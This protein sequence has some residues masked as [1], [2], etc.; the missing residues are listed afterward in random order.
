[1]PPVGGQNK[2]IRFLKELEKYLVGKGVLSALS[3]AEALILFFSRMT[4]PEFYAGLKEISPS[5]KKKILSAAIKRGRGVPSGHI[6][7]EAYFC[8]HR[9]FVNRHVLTPRP[10]TELLV[11]E[12]L[13]I[14][15]TYLDEEAPEILDLGTGSGC[16]AASLT[17]AYPKGRMTALDCSSKA[18]SLAHKN[19]QRLKLSKKIR[20]VKSYFFDAFKGKSIHRWDVIVSNPPYVPAEDW[21]ALPREVQR[22][23]KLAL[24]GG[25]KGLGAVRQILK[26]VPFYLKKPGWVIL[27]IGKG[28]SKILI[29]E[30]GS[31]KVFSRVR[32]VKDLAGIDRILIAQHG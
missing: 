24:L 23:P 13:K 17:I 2:N 21:K 3:E 18:L 27:E 26:D 5:E 11:D 25:K 1:M 7:G 12:T 10:E 9:F 30:L 29:K 15:G 4:R 16:I 32:L 31:N 8:G 6:T 28:Q 20:L 14:L 19:M 22:E